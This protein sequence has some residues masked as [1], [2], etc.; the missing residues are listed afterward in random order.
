MKTSEGSLNLPRGTLDRLIM[1]VVA[2]GPIHGYAIAQRIQQMSP[3]ACRSSR[4][5][6]IRLFPSVNTRSSSPPA[7][8]PTE[9]P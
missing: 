4:S 7:G 8:G 2:L 3:D 6:S 9:P 5:P 1:R